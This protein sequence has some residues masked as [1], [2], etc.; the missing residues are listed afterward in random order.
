MVLFK[1][2]VEQQQQQKKKCRKMENERT[3]SLNNNKTKI[4]NKFDAQKQNGCFIF[5][6]QF[7]CQLNSF[8]SFFVTLI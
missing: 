2:L 4:E 5:K 8:V 7:V 1:K 6:R 3:R